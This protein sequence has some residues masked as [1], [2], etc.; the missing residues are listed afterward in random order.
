MRG[1]ASLTPPRIAVSG[2]VNRE[3]G[4]PRRPDQLSSFVPSFGS[5]AR[6]CSSR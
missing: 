4:H 5:T 2:A 1:G 3:A 6:V